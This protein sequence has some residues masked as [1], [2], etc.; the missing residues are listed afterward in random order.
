MTL[1]SEISQLVSKFEPITLQEMDAVRLMRR[2][3]TKY[4][5]SANKL[6]LL[7]EKAL[8]DFRVVEICGMREQPYETVYFDTPTFSMYKLHH[9]GKCDRYKVRMR[10]YISS[11]DMF[12]E[13]KHK[14]NKGETIKSRIKIDSK[15][16]KINSPLCS[17]FVDTYTPF[18]SF[19]LQPKLGNR[20]IR[21]T[22]VNKNLKERVT[23]DYHLCFN[24]ITSSKERNCEGIC[25]AEVKCSRDD[26]HTEFIRLLNETRVKRSGFSKYC[27]GTAMLN[28]KVK[29]NLFK[30]RL[31]KIERLMKNSEIEAKRF[32]NM[33][34]YKDSLDMELANQMKRELE[35][36][37][38]I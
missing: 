35:L 21:L 16:T 10:H 27:I 36:S 1:K 3:D 31:R 19:D 11:D 13:V 24:D 14:T 37:N 33:S 34:Q 22:L 6:P 29:S 28:N 18:N 26:C 17:S 2:M 12:L 38:C 15:T 8:P 5:L 32:G 30:L 9:N 25:V 4:V 23:L 20:F 7:L